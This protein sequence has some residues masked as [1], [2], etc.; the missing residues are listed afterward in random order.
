MLKYVFR[1]ISCLLVFTFS[2]FGQEQSSPNLKNKQNALFTIRSHVGIPTSISSNAFRF[3]FKGIYNIDLSVNSRLLNNFVVGLGYERCEFKL[4]K[5]EFVKYQAPQKQNQKPGN[6]S[7][8]YDTKLRI[9]NLFVNIGYDKFKKDNIYLNLSLQ[10]G[11]SLSEYT[12]GIPDSSLFNQ[13]YQSTLISG[14]YIRPSSSANF[15]V[16]PNLAF[17]IFFNYTNLLTNFDPRAPRINQYST[18]R[19]KSNKHGIGWITFGFGF[20]VL[21]DKKKK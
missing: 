9:N 19:D 5:A 15:I 16:S 10:A 6:F 17:N 14:P 4:N 12:D 18:V 20:N 13:P 21:L 2:C 11:V 8:S 3:S 1:I 7:L